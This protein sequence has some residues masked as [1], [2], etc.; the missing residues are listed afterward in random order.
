[1]SQ[2][3]I[4]VDGQKIKIITRA[5]TIVGNFC[6]WSVFING[7]KF[8]VS[9]LEED[10]AIDYAFIRWTKNQK[11]IINV[12][13]VNIDSWNRPIFKDLLSKTYYGS[14]DILFPYGE[15]ESEVL[16]KVSVKDLVYF[17]THFD[18]EPMGTKPHKELVIKSQNS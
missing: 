14:C 15:I 13:F 8:K 4:K 1:M 16:E 11:P 2:R 5:R 18:C 3:T 6:G 17:G 9:V 7:E 10:K 12:Q